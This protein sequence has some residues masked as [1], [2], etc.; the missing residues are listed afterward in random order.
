MKKLKIVL[1][2]VSVMLI[3]LLI[4]RAYNAYKKNLTPSTLRP[5]IIKSTEVVKSQETT[6]TTTEITT[7]ATT[8]D[9][10]EAITETATDATT[11][12]AKE[13]ECEESIK[14][15]KEEL[16]YP[17]CFEI[18]DGFDPDI[19]AEILRYYNMIPENVRISFENNGWRVVC[20]ATPIEDFLGFD[21][22]I[23]GCTDED[24]KTIYINN[25][26]SA[27]NTIIHEMGHYI[28]YA[29]NYPEHTDEFS[30][31]YNEEVGTFLANT[32][33]ITANTNTVCEYFAEAFYQ[34]VQ[35]PSVANTIPKTY[36]YVMKY[37]NEL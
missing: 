15:S 28:E 33:S 8:E 17:D 3:L 2:V 14:C 21:Y 6:E 34:V 13:E 36:E 30:T 37:V 1:I 26:K 5:G 31:I 24:V 9:I 12:V 7:A 19:A 18:Q 16:V 22:S 32:D 35:D 29:C 25:K 27:T 20:S 23:R 10:T 4:P 11:E